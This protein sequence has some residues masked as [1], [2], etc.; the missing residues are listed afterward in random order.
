MKRLLQQLPIL[1][2]GMFLVTGAGAATVI[3][4]RSTASPDSI[5]GLQMWLNAG[6]LSSHEG[7]IVL[8]WPDLSGH[9]NSMRSDSGPTYRAGVLNGNPVLQFTASQS[10]Q[11]SISLP[12]TWTIIYVTRLTGGLNSRTLQAV[13]NNWLLGTWGTTVNSAWYEGDVHLNGDA[14]DTRWRIYSGEGDGTTGYFYSDGALIAES[15][16]WK[17]P[18]VGGLAFNAGW[19]DTE[20]S[21]MEVA[22]VVAYNTALSDADRARVETYL[23]RKYGIP[24]ASHNAK[25]TIQTGAPSGLIDEWP[26]NT[27]DV[28]GSV[29]KDTVGSYDG[30]INGSP[31]LVSGHTGSESQAL[32]FFGPD[33]I[34]LARS[35][36]DDF[37]ICAWIKTTSLGIGT[38]HYQSM[39]I[40]D[41]E[42]PGLADDFGFGVDVN[43]HLMFGDGDGARDYTINGT[44]MVSNGRWNL[45][46]ATRSGVDGEMGIYVN[47]R[48]ENSGLGSVVRLDANSGA[49][50]GAGYDGADAYVGDMSDLR[51]Y[52]RVLSSVEIQQLY[53][54]TTVNASQDGKRYGGLVGLWSFDGSDMNWSDATDGTALDGSPFGG[55]MY[56]HD[57]TLRFMTQKG[58]VAPGKI[59][60]ALSF[61]GSTSCVT[62]DL[63]LNM[64][65]GF[66]LA[67]WIYPR[68]YA[69][70]SGIFGQN[71]VAE[72]GFTSDGDLKGW[73]DPGGNVV[74]SSVSLNHW[75]HVAFA[76]DLTSEALYLDGAQV[77]SQSLSTGGFGSS[78]YYFNIGGCGIW[79]ASGDYFQGM[80][81]DVRVYNRMLSDDEIHALY[82]AGK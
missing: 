77:A 40:Y 80:I 24:L 2:A 31:A 17:A 60:Q 66:T 45:V 32:R 55:T 10:F 14:A 34:Q 65:T 50:V 28:S 68:S 25:V 36:E 23:S 7:N 4:G 53:A 38:N 21:N 26:M 54:H 73:T 57:G 9:G 48:L 41:S 82:L 76:A 75:H 71:D 19:A 6:S 12:S 37:T 56:E 74:G 39:P 11:N 63:S 5:S 29:L 67:G 22:E 78:S 79:S 72:F 20:L 52:D 47:G 42:Q 49:R 33:Y 81:D 69:G 30:I 62:T 35:I 3:N 44:S 51:L 58:S 27:P 43:G 8:T 70:G 59:G 61:D 13:T 15:T 18:P 46:C 64:M 16:D 1:I